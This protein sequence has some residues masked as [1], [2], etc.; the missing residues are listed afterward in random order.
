MCTPKSNEQSPS[1]EK[2]GCWLFRLLYCFPSDG[3][4]KSKG[5]RVTSNLDENQM[6]TTDQK[7]YQDIEQLRLLVDEIIKLE[8][9]VSAT[10]IQSDELEANGILH[11][12]IYA[13]L[14]KRM[15]QIKAEIEMRSKSCTDHEV[16]HTRI[17]PN[18]NLLA[19]AISSLND[20][21]I[22][23]FFTDLLDCVISQITKQHEIQ[24]LK[25][26]HT[27][28]LNDQMLVFCAQ[29]D[30]FIQE[31]GRDCRLRVKGADGE[32]VFDSDYNQS[33]ANADRIQQIYA[34]YHAKP[35]LKFKQI[36]NVDIYAT[37]LYNCTITPTSEWKTRHIISAYIE[38]VNLKGFDFSVDEIRTLILLQLNNIRPNVA[39]FDN[40]ASLWITF[41]KGKISRAKFSV[42]LLKPLS[43]DDIYSFKSM[44][45][46][47]L[48][49]DFVPFEAFKH[50]QFLQSSDDN[51]DRKSN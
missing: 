18:L 21:L 32:S 6:D 7:Q 23:A 44:D 41:S 25:N 42:A 47:Q 39:R 37:L 10:I 8:K 34:A 19:E 1:G 27:I 12:T 14:R 13:T 16:L 4:R 49:I 22:K 45:L 43:F 15:M 5:K 36:F 46:S 20:S 51:G 29:F 9:G 11:G 3:L 38:V 30:H 26:K 50:L 24:M 31:H 2:K 33:A 28:K 48:A 35:C 17:L 40:V